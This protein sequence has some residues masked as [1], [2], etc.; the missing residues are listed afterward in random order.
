MEMVLDRKMQEKRIFPAINILKSSTRREDL[1]LTPEELGAVNTL[2]K[3]FNGM[4]PDE[5]VDQCIN[6]FSKTRNNFE[7]CRMVEKTMTFR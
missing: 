1:L 2:R 6:M 7:F 3:G 5:A 4:K